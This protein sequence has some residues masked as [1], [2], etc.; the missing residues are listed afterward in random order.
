MTTYWQETDS[1]IFF[2]EHSRAY[3]TYIANETFGEKPFL[4]F[5]SFA[6]SRLIKSALETIKT[7]PDQD[8]A[9]EARKFLVLLQETVSSL[10]QLNFDLAFIQPI[11]AFISENNTIIL[12]WIFKNYRIGF[13]FEENSHE[14][15][16]YLVS[17][18]E[19]GEISA[20]GYLNPNIKNIVLWL[21]NFVI[22]HS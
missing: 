15:G 5:F 10:Q 16:W 8:I 9:N 2:P 1:K 13:S 22:A 18:R 3:E 17:K 12:E 19:L 20:S 11:Q 14:S 21:I 7:A 6:E 4:S